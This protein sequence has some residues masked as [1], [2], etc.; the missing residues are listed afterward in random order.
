MP[1]TTQAKF[2]SGLLDVDAP[3]PAG[4]IDGAKYPAGKRYDVYR[5]NV[6]HSLI[7]A[8]KTAFPMVL[9]LIGDQNFTSLAPLFVR[10]HPP[11][12]PVMMFYGADFPDFIAEFA[13]LSNIGYLADAARLDLA[14]RRSYHAADVT[15]LDAKA[16]QN[17]P[18]ETLGEATFALAPATIILRSDW[19]LFDIWRFNFEDGAPKPRSRPQDVLITRP[20][21]DPLPHLLPVGAADWLQALADGQG[22]EAAAETTATVHPDFDLAGA[23]G[24]ALGQGALAIPTTRT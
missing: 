13:P 24:L 11:T 15:P 7:E 6:T 18:A 19:P 10:A 14:I 2:R 12:S 21:F 16:L 1:V 5:N 9:K 4:L 22:F 8:L 17:I 3:V 20:S 23:L